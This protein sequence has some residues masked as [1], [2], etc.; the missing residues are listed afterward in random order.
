MS[1]VSSFAR[2]PKYRKHKATG[3]ALVV[4][5]G[6]SHYLG[7]HGTAASK[8]A[9]SRLVGEW[10]QGGKVASATSSNTT[11]SEVMAAYVRHAKGYYR[12]NGKPT[13]EYEQIV[14]A[15]RKVNPL[16]GRSEAVDFCPLA[17]RAVRDSM[18]AADYCR[19]FSNKQ[20]DRIKRMFRWAAAEELIPASIPQALSMVG[21]LKRGR[22]NARET[23]PVQPVD[24]ATVEIT[25][26]HLPDVAAS[27][28]RLQRLTGMRPQE[29][30][31]MRPCDINRSTDVWTYRPESHKTE[32]Q[33]RERIITIGPKA[34]NILRRY[35]ARDANMHCF[36]PCDSEAKRLAARGL[37]RKT[38]ENC[39][40]RT[41]SNRVKEPKRKA[42]KK[43]S[44]PSYRKA[45]HRACDKAFPHPELGR[46]KQPWMSEKQVEELMRWQSQHRWSPNQ[47]RHAAATEIRQNH[48]LEAAQ[49]VL[50]HA[51]ADTTQIYAERD[52]GKAMDVARAM[53]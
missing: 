19:G 49:A 20:I 6:Q 29:V 2:P 5:N 1:N 18:I 52:L 17:L 15:C 21:G 28:V 13:R 41:G 23:P 44:T 9:Y 32:H 51:N 43:Y 22:T 30:C 33:G 4:I 50:S 12:K 8:E 35:L 48:G 42:G 36:R 34:Q 37:A 25:L 45:I 10:L 38:P 14:E 26:C 46:S 11:V 7:K 3:Q 24:D 31:G 39:G 40:N 47:L 16:Y 53:G 27:M